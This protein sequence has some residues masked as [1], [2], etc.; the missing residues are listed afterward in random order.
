MFMRCARYVCDICRT[1]TNPAEIVLSHEICYDTDMI[2]TFGKAKNGRPKAASP[3]DAALKYLG[4]R[5]RTVREMERYLD[6]C[7]YGEVEVMETVDRLQSLGLLDDRAFAEEFVR[8]RLASKPV[9]R[10]HLREQLYAHELP[11]E[12]IDEALSDVPD[13]T[14]EDNASSI[15]RKYLRQ[16][17]SLPEKERDERVL[18][19][20]LSRGYPF[21]MARAVL[22][23]VKAEAAEADGE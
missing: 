23:R 2:R 12:L 11:R 14:E 22:E 19:R 15:A 5:A 21:D 18:K 1:V 20:I 7:E 9:S 13:D 3:M 17:A 10:A 16:L 6:T 4:Y 8:T